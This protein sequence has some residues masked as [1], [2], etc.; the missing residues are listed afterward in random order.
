MGVT[1]TAL[2][3]EKAEDQD[4]QEAIEW[5]KR[6]NKT[7]GQLAVEFNLR[8]GTDITG[9]SLLGHAFE[10]AEAS[11]VKLVIDSAKVPFISG[12]RKYAEEG[13]FPGGAFDNQMHFGPQVNFDRKLDEPAQMLLF[14][15]QTSGG[16]LLG[17]PREKLDA[18]LARAAELDQF[19]RVVGSVH[20]GTGIEVR[21]EES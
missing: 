13:C 20:G 1:T 15:P 21:Q 14:D 5:M 9:F 4:V 8:A 3:Q 17:V 11:G 7:A 6:L 2:K 18:F 19:A 12:A 10:M 16:L